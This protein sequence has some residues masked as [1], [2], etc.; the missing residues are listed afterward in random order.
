MPDSVFVATWKKIAQIIEADYT[1]GYSGLNL[2]GRV[3]RGTLPEAPIIPYAA[4]FLIDSVENAGPVLTRYSGTMEFEI[5]VF[6][7]GGD[8]AER[9]DNALQL[10]A[11]VMN[12]LTADRSLGLSGKIDDI[13]NSVAALD[14][15]RFG[16]DKTGVAFIKSIVTFQ[17]DRGV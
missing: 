9:T 14:G 8:L 6:A 1:S 15:D 3:I 11:D 16:I 13:V 4:V 12:Q 7:G 2:T 10:A 17:S 5:Y